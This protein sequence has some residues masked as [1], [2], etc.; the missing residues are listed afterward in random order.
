[1]IFVDEHVRLTPAELNLVRGAAA[2]N[3]VAHNRIR[4]RDELLEALLDGLPPHT[5]D[6]LLAFLSE[7]NPTRP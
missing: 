1:M 7:S 5:Q 6:G 2:R 4:T 3:G